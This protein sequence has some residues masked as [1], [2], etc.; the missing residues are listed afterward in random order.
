MIGRHQPDRGRVLVANHD[1]EGTPLVDLALLDDE[2]M[3]QLRIH[4]A[5]VFQGN[6][7]FSDTVFKNIA[8]WLREVKTLD[9]REIRRRARA[10]VT[11]VGLDPGTVLGKQREVLS[12]GM[13]K[14]VAVARAVAMK[15]TLVFYDEPTTGLDPGNASQRRWRRT[16][17]RHQGTTRRTT[18]PRG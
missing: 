9:R 8:L 3:D 18:R 2:G 11:A 5:V 17:L 10:A 7:L 14:R 15:P 13:A 6:A 16:G 12:G 1:L 4:W